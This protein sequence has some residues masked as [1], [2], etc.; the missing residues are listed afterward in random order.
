M[1]VR[2]VVHFK[3]FERRRIVRFGLGSSD[4]LASPL[5][6][7]WV[8][9]DETYLAVRMAIGV[10]KV[11]LHSSGFWKLDA[12]NERVPIKGPRKLSENWKA[13]PRVVI[14]GFPPQKPLPPIQERNTRQ[15]FLFPEP[16]EGYWRDFAVLFSKAHAEEVAPLLPQ[17]SDVVGPLPLRNGGL[18]GS[19]RFSRR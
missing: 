2:Q 14:P 1:W 11:S 12:G 5:W 4:R 6:R 18:R 7:M 19:Q 3:P 15:A 8:Q 16:P 10:S 9:G 17:D 13:G